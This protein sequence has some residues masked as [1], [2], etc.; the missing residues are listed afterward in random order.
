MASV[1]HKLLVLLNQR[2]Y[3]GRMK[4]LEIRKV[5]WSE[6]MDRK[7]HFRNVCVQTSLLIKLS[8]WKST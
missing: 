1:F 2:E 4:R 5:F 3:E 7:E 8:V 6:I